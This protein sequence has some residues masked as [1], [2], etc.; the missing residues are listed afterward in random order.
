MLGSELLRDRFEPAEFSLEE[1]RFLLE[2][3]GESPI[4]ALDEGTP[5]GVNE[6]AVRPMLTRTFELEDLRRHKGHEWAGLDLLKQKI[7]KFLRWMETAA[8]IKRRG[9]PAHVSMYG[10]DG[11]GK[12]YK[13]AIGSDAGIVRSMITG[14]G[15]E[16]ERFAVDL[17]RPKGEVIPSLFD[18]APWLKGDPDRIHDDVEEVWGE[19]GRVKGTWK[20]KHGTLRCTI[21][22]QTEMF[23]TDNRSAYN[24]ARARLIKHL[25]HVNTEIDRHRVLA[26]TYPNKATS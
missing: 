8:E 16:R 7:A 18:I 9:G 5:K 25:R 20:S 2:H 14:P 23:K 17:R 3:L 6:A 12:L 11:A 10:I 13:Y 1:N 15:G 19:E 22:G 26:Q 4:V 21:C 24:A